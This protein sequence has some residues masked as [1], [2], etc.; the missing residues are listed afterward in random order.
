MKEK[1]KE[2]ETIVGAESSRRLVCTI[3]VYIDFD[4]YDDDM[5]LRAPH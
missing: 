5:K 3:Q 2:K 4:K 1:K